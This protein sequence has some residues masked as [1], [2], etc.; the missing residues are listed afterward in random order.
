MIKEYAFGFWLLLC[1]AGYSQR[2]QVIDK[3]TKQP[4]S[5]ATISFGNG[6]GL[7]ADDN[8]MFEFTNNRYSDVDSLFIS[9]LGHEEDGLSTQSI[10]NI[11]QL[12]PSVSE[13]KEVVIT[14]ESLGPYTIKKQ[15]PILHDD[16][17]SSWLPT[18]ESEIAVYFPNPFQK[19]VKIA[20]V[21]LPIKLE[22]TRSRTGQ[23]QKFSTLFKMN[24]YKNEGRQP[25]DRI[26][27]EQ[28]IF[29]V[30]HTDKPKF[31]VD[32]SD[33]KIFIPKNGLFIA[34]QVLGYTDADGKLQHTKKYHEVETRKGIVKI[35]TTF[36][37]L[38]PFTDKFKDRR[39]YVRRIFFKNR[40]WQ[41]FDNN[42]TE[43]NNLIKTNHFN[44]GMGI[45]MQVYKE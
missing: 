34:I 3:I 27:S 41:R 15:S 29:I 22:D 2:Y 36:R 33:Y 25:G 44:Y 7:F 20:S 18:V 23:K 35:P 9:A 5:Y 24:F 16:Y 31:E 26:A 11:I 21:F 1:F 37:P 38:L 12:T 30:K 28:V 19:T 6:N 10:P 42:Y 17:F 43:G 8:G 40:T 45:K 13:L 4:V 32:I 14:A 39:T